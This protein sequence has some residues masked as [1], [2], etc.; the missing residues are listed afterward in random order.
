MSNIIAG[1]KSTAAFFHAANKAQYNGA[2][3]HA[4]EVHGIQ[5]GYLPQHPE[6]GVPGR[7][8][9]TSYLLAARFA[10]KELIHP[11]KI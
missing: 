8:L 7:L 4:P 3:S 9:L 5:N 1:L 10:K 6:M 2:N 11:P